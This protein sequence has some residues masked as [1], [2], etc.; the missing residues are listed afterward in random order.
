MILSYCITIT[1]AKGSSESSLHVQDQMTESLK[2]DPSCFKLTMKNVVAESK[3]VPVFDGIL[4][5]V[6]TRLTKAMPCSRLQ[7]LFFCRKWTEGP[8]EERASRS[9]SFSL[10]RLATS[11]HFLHFVSRLRRRKRGNAPLGSSLRKVLRVF[12][13][14]PFVRSCLMI[15][16][17]LKVNP[18]SVSSLHESVLFKH[19][20]VMETCIQVSEMSV[21][22]ED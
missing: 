8:H 18:S 11:I 2:H 12:S 22:G 10:V 4:Q 17:K 20:V 9:S 19:C 16:F 14:L 21:A 15:W 1:A 6:A 3:R 7:N 13:P 5:I